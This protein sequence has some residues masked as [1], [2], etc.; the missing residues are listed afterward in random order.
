MTMA[1]PTRLRL[2][3]A[4]TGCLLAFPSQT[5]AADSA[6]LAPDISVAWQNNQ[7]H[8]G[9]D[10]ASTLVPPLTLKWTRDL[11]SLG[12]TT[13]SYPLIVRGM[14]FITVST[15]SQV[16]SIFALDET[17]GTTIWSADVNGTYSF[18]N[19]AYDAGKV[20]VVNF[21]G[22][23]KAFR[24]TNGSLLWSVQLP[25]QYAFTSPPTAR[26]GV[27]YTGGAG[28]GGTLYA[29]DESNGNVLWTASVEN[30]DH[31][32]P[33]LAGPSVYVSYACPQSYAFD[34]RSGALVWHYSGQC[35]GGGGKTP[36][37]HQGSVYV[38]D[39]FFSS[40]NG[41][42]LDAMSGATVGDFE[43]ERPP[44]FV[45]N[46]G[47]Y[48]QLG[49]L[50]GVDLTTED[51][52]WSFAGNGDLTSAPLIVN[53]TIYVGGSSGLLYGLNFQ[54]Q[55]VWNTQVGAAIPAPDEQNAFLTTGFGAG[56]GLLIIPTA[57]TLVAYGN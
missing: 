33:A 15:S 24:A 41:L 5:P 49:T 38:R 10:S 20:F 9:Y 6:T 28:S 18:A 57:S 42:I 54:G 1:F 29:V 44:A 22:L 25:G 14:V 19:A 51:V 16:D 34:A 48:Y 32:S 43:S 17:T 13:I 31:S 12:V 40:V 8:D 23:M 45:R 26:R 39:N 46:T 27:V 55:A 21:D 35:E 50:R 3:I 30:G 11:S 47:I 7:N 4:L 2:V 52:L 53:K 56:D 37:V 36:V